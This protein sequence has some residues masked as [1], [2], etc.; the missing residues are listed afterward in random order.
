MQIADI[1]PRGYNN[2]ISGADLLKISGF[3]TM[4]ELRRQINAERLQG[5]PILSTRAGCGGY[6]LPGN[7]NETKE[8]CHTMRSEAA[9]LL[10]VCD[11]IEG[12]K[13]GEAG[14]AEHAAKTRLL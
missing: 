9:A 4:R 13:H 11:A 3:F 12:N 2:R 7:Q 8:F 6:Y 10:K 1:I 5:A 14:K